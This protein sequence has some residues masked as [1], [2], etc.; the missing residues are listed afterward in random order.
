MYAIDA[1]GM[2]DS[3]EALLQGVLG[4]QSLFGHVDPH[5]AMLPL[6][7]PDFR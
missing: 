1:F 3:I 5:M 2:K 7:V 4:D 6:P